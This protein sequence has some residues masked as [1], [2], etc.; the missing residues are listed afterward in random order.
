M[1][2][3]AAETG[4]AS[5]KNKPYC[6]NFELTKSRSIDEAIGPLALSMAEQAISSLAY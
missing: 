1:Q 2:L 5:R 6:V 3:A 4:I